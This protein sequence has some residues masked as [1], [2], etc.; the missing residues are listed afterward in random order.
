[1]FRCGEPVDARQQGIGCDRTLKVERPTGLVIEDSER[2]RAQYV[3]SCS[4]DGLCSNHLRG[5]T[6]FEAS[7]YRRRYSWHSGAGG[8]PRSVAARMPIDPLNGPPK[9]SV[10]VL[11]AHAFGEECLASRCGLVH[12]ERQVPPFPIHLR[13]LVDPVSEYGKVGS[14]VRAFEIGILDDCEARGGAT[15]DP[16]RV[17]AGRAPSGSP[18]TDSKGPKEDERRDEREQEQGG[19]D[20]APAPSRRNQLR[21]FGCSCHDVCGGASGGSGSIP[22]ARSISAARRSAASSSVSPWLCISR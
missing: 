17:S 21:E 4:L 2:R 3:L 16:G 1:M 20:R 13:V 19:C 11:L 5:S 6:T 22:R 18:G 7:L 14:A 9:C 10:A 15:V 12:R 8:D